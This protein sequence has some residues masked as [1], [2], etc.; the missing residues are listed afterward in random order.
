MVSEDCFFNEILFCKRSDKV[1][2]SNYKDDDFYSRFHKFF[3]QS[4][5]FEPET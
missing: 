3:F 5:Y 1:N 4:L 2:A